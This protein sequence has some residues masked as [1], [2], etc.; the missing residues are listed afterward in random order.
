MGYQFFDEFDNRFAK[1]LCDLKEHI[2]EVYFP[3]LDAPTCRNSLVNER[4]T[5]NWDAQDFLQNDLKLLKDN[6]IRLNLLLNANCYGDKA[7][8]NYLKNYVCSII[9]HIIEIAGALDVVTTTSPFI[10]KI[11]KDNFKGV[12]TRAS[13]NMGIGEIKG[14][15]YLEQMFD[16]YYLQRDYN[17]NLRHISKLKEWTDFAGK[18]LHLLANSGC[19][20]FCSGQIFHDNLVAHEQDIR[21]RENLEGFKSVTCWNYYSKNQNWASLLQNTWIRPEDI[22]HYDGLFSTVKIA[23]RMTQ[24]PLTVIKAY[25]QGYYRGNVLNLLEPNHTSLLEG[26]YLDNSAFPSDW[27]DQTSNCN[28]DCFRCSYCKSIL[29]IIMVKIPKVSI[30]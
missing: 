21:E 9:Q 6:G 30:F 20:K 2:E 27:F 25:I 4:G 28:C 24:R 23:T 18:T 10:A 13:V 12:K 5:I 1:T 29:D 8:S 22:H 3:W 16:G 7:I 15:Q 19:M 11:V 17:R 26:H 14:M